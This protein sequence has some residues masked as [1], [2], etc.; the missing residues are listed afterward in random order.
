MTHDDFYKRLG[1]F[2]DQYLK[3]LKVLEAN[4]GF[5]ARYGLESAL[6]SM[7]SYQRA[8]QEAAASISK[9]D[10]FQVSIKDTLSQ[11]QALEDAVKAFSRPSL[12]EQALGSSRRAEMAAAA[13]SRNSVIDD[14]MK[15]FASQEELYKRAL[16][17]LDIQSSIASALSGIGNYQAEAE[18]A[19]KR[20]LESS[21]FL[22]E[23]P[24]YLRDIAASVADL[25]LDEADS[26]D[27]EEELGQAVHGLDDVRSAKS[28]ADWFKALPPYVQAFLWFFLLQVIV[29]QINSISANLL[30]PMVQSVMEQEQRSERD[31]INDV[32]KIRF[33]LEGIDT[34]GLRFISGTNVRLRSQPSTKSEVLD[35][36]DLG[37]VVAVVSKE[38]NWIEIQYEYEDGETKVGWVFARYTS[39][40]KN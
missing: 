28:F 19:L 4:M 8:L 29:P 30:T 7:N 16:G 18:A 34:E 5:S 40:F 31:K 10:S 9:Y 15:S 37:Q 6:T 36:L 23:N 1:L 33:D 24:D 20:I 21:S 39:K 3:S 38:R 26:Q 35:E 22:F 11:N 25:K 27:V 12:I 17:S 13:M 14:A 2:P 32:R